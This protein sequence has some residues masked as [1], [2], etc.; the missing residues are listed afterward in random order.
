M[1][2]SDIIAHG[3]SPWTLLHTMSIKEVVANMVHHN[4]N[5][6]LVVD[7]SNK[8]VGYISIQDIAKAIVPPEFV[9]NPA[10]AKAMYKENF[11]HDLCD[12]MVNESISSIMKKDLLIID[13]DENIMAVFSLFLKHDI[14]FLCVQ[15]NDIIVAVLTR[16][17]MKRILADAMGI[18][19]K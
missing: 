19:W 8:P 14:Y 4:H 3:H 11:L 2:L 16:R 15:Q 10:I 7:E 13:H 18:S 5:S 1:L 17:D 6:F 9:T 12:E